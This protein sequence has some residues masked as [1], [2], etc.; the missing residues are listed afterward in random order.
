MGVYQAL[1]WP[2]VPRPAWGRS[3]PSQASRHAVSVAGPRPDSGVQGRSPLVQREGR[4]GEKA[5]TRGN[6]AKQWKAHRYLRAHRQSTGTSVPTVPAMN[7]NLYHRK[8]P[9][10]CTSHNPTE[11]TRHPAPLRRYPPKAGGSSPLLATVAALDHGPAPLL[12]L[13]QDLHRAAVARPPRRRGMTDR[14]A[15]A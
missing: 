14:W 10:T 5:S 8:I 9:S 1:N 12:H 13:A 3:L 11:E 4:G 6:T 2:P 15:A 7:N